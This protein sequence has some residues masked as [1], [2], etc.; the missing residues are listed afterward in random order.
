[1]NKRIVKFPTREVEFDML[2]AE[3]ILKTF[4]TLTDD[5]KVKL[6]T[7]GITPTLN[8]RHVITRRAVRVHYT[9]GSTYEYYCIADAATAYRVTKEYIQ[10]VAEEGRLYPFVDHG[11]IVKIDI[12]HHL[13]QLYAQMLEHCKR[14]VEVVCTD[15]RVITANSFSKAAA[16]TGYNNRAL[17]QM[18]VTDIIPPY[19]VGV[20][21][22]VRLLGRADIIPRGTCTECYLRLEGTKNILTFP[23][24]RLL[25]EYLQTNGL[26]KMGFKSL[27][28]KLNL[29]GVYV[30]AG[31]SPLGFRITTDK[32]E[33]TSKSLATQ[34]YSSESFHVAGI[35]KLI[36]KTTTDEYIVYRTYVHV[37]KQLG[38]DKEI[39]S[40]IRDM[41]VINGYTLYTPSAWVRL[42]R[43]EKRIIHNPKK[44]GLLW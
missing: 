16:I 21:K 4:N 36:V 7:L 28:N 44:G 22:E 25:L 1:M 37:A 10:K 18:Y 38:V 11:D 3:G 20:I 17:Y 12:I 40:G 26:T 6:I 13:G 33:F 2:T 5:E 31:L 19:A 27:F 9:N 14:K 39:I 32:S 30:H 29:G 42:V 35:A 8:T 15:G 24:I 43:K 41:A 34:Y 23:T